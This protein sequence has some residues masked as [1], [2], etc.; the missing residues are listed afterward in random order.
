[1]EN[2]GTSLPE[3]DKNALL[4]LYS[5]ICKSYH[6]IDDFRMKLLSLLPLFSIVGV[7]FI[8]KELK[9]DP[10]SEVGGELIAFI[11]VFAALFTIALFIYE[12]RGIIRSTNLIKQGRKIEKIL[13]FATN[14]QFYVCA[15]EQKKNRKFAFNSTFAACLVDSLVF[16]AWLY[17]FLKI[18]PNYETSACILSAAIT[19]ITIAVVSN[20]V[21]NKYFIAA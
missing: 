20:L 19:G 3:L 4:N 11:S 1:M 14:G 2:E 17:V 5:E 16:A 8:D 15:E 9:V 6:V 13:G 18:G 21:L 10:G 7:L 12:I